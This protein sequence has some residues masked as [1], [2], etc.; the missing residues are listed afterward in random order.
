M[1]R[2]GNAAECM[3]EGVGMPVARRGVPISVRV[4]P[5]LAKRL[6]RLVGKLAKDRGGPTL[7]IMN[8]SNVIKLALL[9][10]CEALEAEL[11]GK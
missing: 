10:G 6:D 3:V 5:E 11:S 4:P 1:V 8:K 7:G 2:A 9:K